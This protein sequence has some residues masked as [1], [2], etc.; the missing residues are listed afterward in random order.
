MLTCIQVKMKF[1]QHLLVFDVLPCRIFMFS[2]NLFI[3]VCVNYIYIYVYK[4]FPL[5]KLEYTLYTVI[6]FTQSKYLIVLYFQFQYC[7]NFSAFILH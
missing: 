6:C 3:S 5:Q 1:S 4:C 7:G 2:I